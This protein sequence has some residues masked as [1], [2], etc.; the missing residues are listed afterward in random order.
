MCN[1]CCHS[2]VSDKIPNVFQRYLHLTSAH[3]QDDIKCS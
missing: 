2:N 1:K 3:I